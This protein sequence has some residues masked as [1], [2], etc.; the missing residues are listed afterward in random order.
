MECQKCGFINLWKSSL[1]LEN[2]KDLVTLR[3]LHKYLTSGMQRL[4]ELEISMMLAI[5][6]I[7]RFVLNFI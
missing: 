4:Q 3:T 6:G 5:R 7:Y 1:E 2:A